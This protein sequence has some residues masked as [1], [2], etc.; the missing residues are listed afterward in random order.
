M[1]RVLTS[2]DCKNWQSKLPQCPV[3]RVGHWRSPFRPG[4]FQSGW[5][6]TNQGSL[7][8]FGEYGFHTG[9]IYLFKINVTFHFPLIFCFEQFSTWIWRLLFAVWS[10][11][12]PLRVTFAANGKWQISDW[13]WE[14]FRKENN[15]I[16][17]IQN[18]SYE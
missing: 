9:T 6:S 2:R 17:T 12:S 15:Q 7:A 11:N 16:K 5:A 1:N 8:Q 4:E 13:S 10:L 18:N 14:F 3:Y